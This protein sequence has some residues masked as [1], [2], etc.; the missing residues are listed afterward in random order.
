MGIVDAKQVA[1]LV[2]TG[3]ELTKLETVAQSATEGDWLSKAER[4]IT[5]INTLFGHVEALRG[6]QNANDRQ[7]IVSDGP[8]DNPRT[9][10]PVVARASGA[11]SKPENPRKGEDVM[12]QL[13]KPAL[14][15]VNDYLDKCRAENP[16]MTIG[17]ALQKAPI[18]VTQ[19]RSLLEVLK[20]VL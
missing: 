18:N 20:G 2:K 1:A 7:I 6:N 17:E 12:N 11:E 4:I 13:V 16:N 10:G 3:K 14:Q 8:R 19:L 5:G 15:L 9:S